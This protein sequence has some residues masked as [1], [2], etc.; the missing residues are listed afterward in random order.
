MK[1]NE[2]LSVLIAYAL[3]HLIGLPYVLAVESAP[4][5]DRLFWAQNAPRVIKSVPLPGGA[6]TELVDISFRRA[7]FGGL[8]IDQVTDTLYYA[9]TLFDT[10]RRVPA[11]GGTSELLINLTS[12]PTSIEVDSSSR[13]LYWAE[14]GSNRIQVADIDALLPQTLIA[15]V[16]DPRGID[17]DVTNDQIYWVEFGTNSLRRANLDGNNVETLIS[18]PIQR[19]FDVAVDSLN[20]KLYWVELGP[21]P[22]NTQDNDDGRVYRANIDGSGVELLFSGLFQPVNI[23]LD[24][25]RD[26]MYWSVGN[27]IMV[28]DLNGQNASVFVA[29]TGGP[30]K[31]AL[32]LHV[33]PEPGSI[34]L[35][36]LCCSVVVSIRSGRPRLV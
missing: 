7:T 12:Q 35:A 28:A 18:A 16:T 23:E 36:F 13:M 4:I 5:T 10:I 19:P 11:S 20:G 6:E 32:D 2:I 17:L 8:D 29:N 27:E 15:G 30:T 22:N 24:V 9:E 33:I 21:D 1:R 14:R 25:Y 26:R 3:C 34:V 31:L